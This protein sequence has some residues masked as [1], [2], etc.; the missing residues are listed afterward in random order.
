MNYGG[1][2]SVHHDKP[3]TFVGKLVEAD[4]GAFEDA[5][6]MGLV[7]V[8]LLSCGRASGLF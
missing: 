6:R 7:P 3:V 4:E 2:G 8:A 5:A 1:K